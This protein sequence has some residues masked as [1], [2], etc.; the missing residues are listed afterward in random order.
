MSAKSKARAARSFGQI[1]R[2]GMTWTAENAK[3]ARL[4]GWGLYDYAWTP[5]FTS[6][7]DQMVPSMDVTPPPL[8]KGVVRLEPEFWAGVFAMQREVYEHVKR[9]SED[10]SALHTKALAM[11]LLT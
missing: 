2:M 5:G 3:T 6:M 7:H 8:A 10:G 4:E 1:E 9:R 11:A